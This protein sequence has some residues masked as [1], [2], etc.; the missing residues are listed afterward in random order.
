MIHVGILVNKDDN[1]EMEN[2]IDKSVWIGRYQ[3]ISEGRIFILVDFGQGA[4][5]DKVIFL[6]C[7]ITFRQWIVNYQQPR[8]IIIQN[9]TFIKWKGDVRWNQ[10]LHSDIGNQLLGMK[11]LFCFNI[12]VLTV[13]V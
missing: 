9:N 6:K 11:F 4:A 8:S 7:G 13:I 5:K 1:E 10:D 2:G 12:S 3:I